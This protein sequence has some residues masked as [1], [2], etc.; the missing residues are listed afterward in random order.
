MLDPQPGQVMLDCTIGRGG[1]MRAIAPK[2]VPGGRYIGLDVDPGSLDHV[3]SANDAQ[4]MT[5]ELV[6]ANFADSR[7]AL[8]QLAIDRV[9]LLLADIGF[10]STQVD[11]ASRGF[12]FTTDGP[13]D[14]RL[15]PT[16]TR[17]AADLLAECEEAEIAD[18]LWR[19][20]EERASRMIAR[21]VV[22]QRRTSPISS[23]R[24]LAD[25]CVSVYAK[26]AGRGRAT[27]RIHPATRSFQALRIA[28]NDELGR[29]EALLESVGEL[30]NHEGRA[31]IISFHSLEDRLVK[32]AFRE[33]E[34]S[35]RGER[36]TRKP[37]VPATQE[38]DANPRS[39]SAKLRAVRIFHPRTV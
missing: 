13:L 10:A 32:H 1:H 37:L 12:S 39:R 9:D 26:R 4:S 28:V 16:L 2:L 34:D 31:A 36:L 17:T 21:K 23:T 20:G 19:F 38:I 14:M 30:L 18:I 35:G 8:D 3:R 6:Q 5:V 29:L 24:Q 27:W 22:D 15:D 7:A 11:D 25:L 33:V